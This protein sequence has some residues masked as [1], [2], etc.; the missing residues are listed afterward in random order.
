MALSFP[1]GFLW[2]TS[3]ASAQIETASEHQWKG[4]VS[5]TG[6]VFGRTT[7]HEKRREEDLEIICSLGGAY[8]MSVDWARLQ[9]APYAEFDPAV[10]AEY[11]VFMNALQARGMHV[12]LVFHH[13]AEP[14]W[15]ADAGGFERAEAIPVFV[16]F[17]R[18]MIAHFG[19]YA[20]SFNTFNEPGG[21]LMMGWF[22]GA[23]PPYKKNFITMHRALGN[24][25]EAHEQV[26]RL[27]KEAFPDK[28]V[29]ISKHTMLYERENWTGWLA[30]QFSNRYYLGTITDR[31]H[32][33]ADFVGMS[34]YGRVPLAPMPISE[35]DTP[36]KLADRGIRHDDMWEYHPAGIATIIK[37]FHE[38]YGLPVW[39]T[40]NG[41]C[42]NDDSFRQESI[43]DYLTAIHGCIADGVPVQAYFHWCTWDNFEWFLG[44]HYRFGLY[45]TDFKTMERTPKGSATLYAD[46]AQH[47]RLP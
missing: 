19:R 28:P 24:M 5:R 38:R 47:N 26:Y 15:F 3:T 42:T 43:R 10:V 33:L 29:G 40:E 2:G 13:F 1:P 36:G 12:M 20:A 44:P 37:R 11:S 41:L 17:S 8:R 22:M 21:F 25:A 9:A 14:R 45:H 27:L 6:E 23:F 46:I 32:R 34:Y 30:E 16:D 39:I 31:F 7:D 35:I 18:K 4:V